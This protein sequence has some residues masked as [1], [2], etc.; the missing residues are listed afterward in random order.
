MKLSPQRL[1]ACALFCALTAVCSQI[2]LPLPFTPVPVNLA[3]LSVFLA[4][5]LLG[6]VGGSWSIA[7]YL[8]LG[9]VGVPVFSGLRGGVSALAG[10]TGGYLVGYLLAVAVI[11]LLVSHKETRLLPHAFAMTIGLILCYGLGTLWFMVLTRNSLS[12]SLAMCVLPFLPGD[13]LKIGA[14]S[15]L[16]VRVKKAAGNI[17]PF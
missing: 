10:P 17:I 5:G 3:T 7:A 13:A 15:L 4:G 11:G 12:T 16:C 8:L 9:C 6:A 14:A 2:A 1:S